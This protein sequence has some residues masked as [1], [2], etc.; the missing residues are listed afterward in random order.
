MLQMAIH[1]KQNP[2]SLLK[3]SK[4]QR[5]S[6]SYLEQI[7]AQLRQHGL[8]KGLRGP[9]GGYQLAKKA[10]EISVGEVVEAVGELDSGRWSAPMVAQNYN[11]SGVSDEARGHWNVLSEQLHGLLVDVNLGDLVQSR[12][13]DSLWQGKGEKPVNRD[14]NAA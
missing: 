4:C 7:L 6:L 1:Q 11:Y 12:A 2:I 14:R 13:K 5:V 8:V 3:L 9:G 10:D